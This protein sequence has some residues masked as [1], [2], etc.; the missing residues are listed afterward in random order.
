MS[1]TLI[2]RS[3]LNP[4]SN[5]SFP[6]EIHGE[7]APISRKIT[8]GAQ[9]WF[10][11]EE[12]PIAFVYNRRNYAVMMGTP[13]DL[14]DFAVGFS[15]TEEVI[16]TAA[17]IKS[18]DIHL[19]DKGA[20]I[21]FKITP[22]A[23]ERLEIT[24]RRRNMVGSASCGL[25]GLENAETLFKVLPKVAETPTALPQETLDKAIA[26]IGAHQPLNAQTRSVHAAA[27]VNM[28]GDII[29]TREDVG[30]HNALDKLLGAL[31]IQNAN[32]STGFVLMSSRCS[33]EIVE[34]AARRGVKAVLSISGPTAL[35]LRKA[36]EAN[37]AIYARNGQGAVRLL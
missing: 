15:L 17:D 18:I 8:A 28:E 13:D 20:D 36:E 32:M 16:K 21:R 30:R 33:Y 10:I 11:P 26:A 9:D 1:L 35:A 5:I 12:V 24:Q 22:D 3:P 37:M 25:C 6:V 27:W 23:V 19:S 2:A 29:C 14:V 34:K 4:P 31:A 7:T